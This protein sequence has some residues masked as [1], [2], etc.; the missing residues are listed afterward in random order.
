MR[1]QTESIELSGVVEECSES[2]NFLASFVFGVAQTGG[3]MRGL[4]AVPTIQ[5]C[6]LILYVAQ[7]SNDE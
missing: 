7:T 4:S 6:D 3:F 1:C 2:L 5:S